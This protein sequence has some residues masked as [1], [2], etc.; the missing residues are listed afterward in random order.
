M[1]S[2]KGS[3]QD[4]KYAYGREEPQ[5]AYFTGEDIY[6]ERLERRRYYYDRNIGLL[7]GVTANNASREEDQL[8]FDTNHKKWPEV[9]RIIPGL[10]SEVV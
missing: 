5:S 10:A 7:N 4:L 3:T 2:P 6:A 1:K 9:S 8:K